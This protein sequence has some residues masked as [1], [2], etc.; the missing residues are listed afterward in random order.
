MR[1]RLRLIHLVMGGL[2]FGMTLKLVAGYPINVWAEG[3]APAKPPVV[4]ANA[5]S[6]PKPATPAAAEPEKKTERCLTGALVASA[7]EKLALLEKRE[8]QVSERERLIEVSERRLNEQMAR[9][10]AVRKKVSETAGLAEQKMGKDRSKLIAIYEQMKPKEAAGIFN[11]MDTVVASELLRSM[12]EQSSSGILAAMEPK[13]A[14]EVTI[15]MSSFLKQREQ[16]V[17]ALLPPK[18]AMAT[19]PASDSPSDATDSAKP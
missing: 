9:L 5:P 10:E 8:Q 12:R 4:A 14:Y 2:G 18:A 15:V 13:K 11:E 19:T 6:T 3:V 16:D 17:S 7:D 1:V